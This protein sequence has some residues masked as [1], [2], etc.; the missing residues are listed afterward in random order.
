MHER[1]PTAPGDFPIFDDIVT[2]CPHRCVGVQMR[3]FGS[4]MEAR[5]RAAV[6]KGSV[7]STSLA[8]VRCGK[9]LILSMT[10]WSIFFF[11]LVPSLLL[12]VS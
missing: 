11:L 3:E 10:W 12:L 2:A 6:V 1:L 5:I 9:S 7:T 8:A 4:V